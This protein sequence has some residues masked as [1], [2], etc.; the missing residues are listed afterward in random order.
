MASTPGRGNGSEGRRRRRS[1]PPPPRSSTRVPLRT[2]CTSRAGRKAQVRRPTRAAPWTAE[3][4]RT[5]RRAPPGP[6]AP[7]ATV[8]AAST[9][10]ATRAGVARPPPRLR[11]RTRA[12][13]RSRVATGIAR[14][15]PDSACTASLCRHNCPLS[16][17]RGQKK[18]PQPKVGRRLCHRL[19]AGPPSHGRPTSR[20]AGL[21]TLGSSLPRAFP[22][23]LPSA[24]YGPMVVGQW[25]HAS[26][27]PDHSGGTARDSHPIP[28]SPPATV[29]APREAPAS[30]DRRHQAA[31][32]GCAAK[33]YHAEAVA[34]KPPGSSH[35][36]SVA[37]VWNARHPMISVLS[38]YR[39]HPR[40]RSPSWPPCHF[41]A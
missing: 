29:A 18:S 20:R 39:Y 23:P 21:L 38:Y 13:A 26:S 24:H 31:L 19:S 30:P 22:S 2:G 17:S 34:V 10:T 12:R 11:P 25:P 4:T 28:Y 35:R 6:R 36:T 41:V 33:K 7:T 5:G 9:A 16:G 40:L 3:G 37:A 8:N 32:L 14:S 15:I 1:A 27:L